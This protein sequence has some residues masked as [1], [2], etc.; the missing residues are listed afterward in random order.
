MPINIKRAIMGIIVMGL[1][2][3]LF[4]CGNATAQTDSSASTTK[5]TIKPTTNFTK[6][7]YSDLALDM[8]FDR[9]TK[10]YFTDSIETCDRAIKEAEDLRAEYA[11]MEPGR[12]RDAVMEWID[13]YEN[14]AKE[15]KRS[16][17]NNDYATLMAKY[18]EEQRVKRERIEALKQSL[19]DQGYSETWPQRDR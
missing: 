19:K 11:K 17:R 2:G 14:E 8:V 15:I 6:D 10:V 1:F 18:D 3:F 16:T 9:I 4:N 7:D 13:Y 5:S 12:L